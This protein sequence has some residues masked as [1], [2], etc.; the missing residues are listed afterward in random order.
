MYFIIANS[1][2]IR[3]FV[4]YDYNNNQTKKVRVIPLIEEIW[5]FLTWGR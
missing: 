5:T 3:H 4:A 2:R 1:I